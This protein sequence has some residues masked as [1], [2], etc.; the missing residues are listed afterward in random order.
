MPARLII[1]HD[2]PEFIES[3]VMALRG[4]GYD[5]LV[6]AS[7]MA[8]LDALEAARSVEVLITRVL[9]PEGQPNGIALVRMTR[10]KRPEVKVL[11]VARSDTQEHTEGEFLPAGVTASEIVKMVGKMLAA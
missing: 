11:F 1:A 3:I 4:H 8:A 9:F 7:S 10:L 2:D 6:F 5:V